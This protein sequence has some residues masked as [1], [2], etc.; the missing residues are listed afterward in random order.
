M[1]T[2]YPDIA[3]AGVKARTMNKIA[4]RKE[5]E[6]WRAESDLRTLTEAEEIKR[7]PKRLAM[8]QACAKEKLIEMAA[9]AGAAGIQ[10]EKKT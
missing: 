3:L 8:A 2:R 1:A 5:E 9:V 10:P 7:D 4:M 6:K